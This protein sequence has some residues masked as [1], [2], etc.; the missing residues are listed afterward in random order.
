MLDIQKKNDIQAKQKENQMQT[1][2]LYAL[3]TQINPHFLYNTLDSIRG[4][5]VIHQV[6]E[7]ADMTEALS[8]LFR[9]MIAKEGKLLRVKEEFESVKNY[10]AIQDF[11]FQHKFHYECEV[12]R[13]IMEEY[14][15]PNMSLQPLVENA[16][17]HGLEQKMGM[18]IVRITGY[19]TEKRLVLNVWDN[20]IGISEKKL[21]ILNERI[22]NWRETESEKNRDDHTGIA[23]M[24]INKRIKLQFGEE[25]GIY[26]MSTPEISTVT[27]LT[28]PAIRVDE[29][30]EKN[31]GER[32]FTD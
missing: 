19:V 15:I 10:I 11:R 28:L 3:Q 30:G 26:I 16:I 31:Y 23:L 21:R 5:A 8:K 6:Y 12:E 1:T 4:Y 20:G 24:N 9:S 32:N 14:L 29:Y 18:G 13:E 7:I 25:F 22:L 17:M 27:E 2:E